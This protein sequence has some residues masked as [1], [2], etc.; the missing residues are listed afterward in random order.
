[1]CFCCRCRLVSTQMFCRCI[2]PDM[3]H[4]HEL[5]ANIAHSNW[6]FV[7]KTA[8]TSKNSKSLKRRI[9]IMISNAWFL[10][11]YWFV[12][13]SKKL[14]RW[15]R[16]FFL[17]HLNWHRYKQSIVALIYLLDMKRIIIKKIDLYA[18]ELMMMKLKYI[19]PLTRICTKTHLPC[20]LWSEKYVEKANCMHIDHIVHASMSKSLCLGVFLICVHSYIHYEPFMCWPLIVMRIV[21]GKLNGL[22]L[23]YIE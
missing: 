6:A 2:V 14:S 1:M 3:Q 16:P 17:Y 22:L 23:E 13:E 8:T 21:L 4:Q 11:I 15:C 19:T 9:I 20:W 10:R 5:N 7:T 18:N 12:F